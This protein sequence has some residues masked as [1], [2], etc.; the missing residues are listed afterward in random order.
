MVRYQQTA[1]R[2]KRRRLLNTNPPHQGTRCIDDESEDSIASRVK[3]RRRYGAN[4]E[5]ISASSTNQ[6]QSKNR[7][8]KSK[9]KSKS[10]EKTKAPNK[11]D[12][13]LPKYNNNLNDLIFDSDSAAKSNNNKSNSTIASDNENEKDSASS[14]VNN[15]A[16]NVSQTMRNQ[17]SNL[18][19]NI[20][21]IMVS[22]L[23]SNLLKCLRLNENASIIS[24]INK[25]LNKMVK[26]TPFIDQLTIYFG[27]VRYVS[28][29]N[30]NITHSFYN[31]DKFIQAMK[32]FNF[33]NLHELEIE[34]CQ[35]NQSHSIH[36]HGWLQRFNHCLDL[37]EIELIPYIK[38]LK[39]LSLEIDSFNQQ[40]INSIC[41]LLNN[42]INTLHDVTINVLHNVATKRLIRSGN[43]AFSSCVLCC[44]AVFFCTFLIVFFCTLI[45]RFRKTECGRKE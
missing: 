42:N 4:N 32:S 23:A 25:E 11:T 1:S 22:I 39:L 19:K 5:E 21:D 45:N 6:N 24:R 15:S 28:I 41:T 17:L 31:H 10:K 40:L 26:E 18:M 35:I 3:Q 44:F 13:V 9:S 16:P 12:T 34:T 43:C 36:D 27:H 14:D 30:N 38:H 2:N 33:H 20:D 29:S 8:N 7:L 37:L